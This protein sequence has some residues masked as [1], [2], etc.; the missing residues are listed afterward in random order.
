MGQEA[1]K[2]GRFLEEFSEGDVFRHQLGKTILESDN[3]LFCL[4]TMNHHPVHLDDVYAHS[5]QHGKILV[6][7]TLVFSLVVGLTVGDISGRAI[8]NLE[9]QGIKH[10]L[11]VHVGDT[12]HAETT[13]LEVI[14]SK[15]KMDR[16]T[17]KVST[18]AY[19]QDHQAVLEFT[20]VLLVPKQ[21][22]A[23]NV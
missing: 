2:F 3:N 13:V 14:S 16:G 22:G 8:A 7:G 23:E 15:T 18:V 10:L 20:R 5:A 12:I 4:L 1:H 9:Y 21:S 6:V 11:P 17:V 19:N